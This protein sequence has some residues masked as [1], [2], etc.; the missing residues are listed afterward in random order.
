[1]T[2]IPGLIVG[3]PDGAVRALRATDG[4]LLWRRR[5]AHTAHSNFDM[6]LGQM[7]NLLLAVT[8]DGV[9]HALR[10]R[11][12]VKLWGTRL[13]AYED[14]PQGP[15]FRLARRYVRM[16]AD[17]ERAVVQFL[18]Q[19]LLLESW[20]GR[21]LWRYLSL[22]QETQMVG[23]G[24]GHVFVRE[25][26]A[27]S[28]DPREARRAGRPVPPPRTVTT[29]TLALSLQDGATSWTTRDYAA[30]AAE[31]YGPTS[32]AVSNSLAFCFGERGL[33]ALREATGELVWEQAVDIRFP[34]G[35]LALT[36]GHVAIWANQ[37]LL[38]FR[39]RDG[40]LAW[41]LAA[42]G[43]GLETE[44][45]GALVAM[46]DSIY[47]G[48]RSLKPNSSRIV[49]RDSATGAITWTWPNSAQGESGDNMWRLCGAN[50]TLYLPG[51]SDL[52]ALRAA[53]GQQQ[54]VAHDPQGFFGALLPIDAVDAE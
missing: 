37:D 15:E 6:P 10:L 14:E 24:A 35:K 39:Q 2:E 53:D 5:I 36:T 4:T 13:P 48:R 45:Y 9:I 43:D 38:V 46:G 42:R 18:R 51:Q 47:I 52:V 22:A 44:M 29:E 23:V 33:Y 50:G 31:T 41:S 19:I 25:H 49:A 21:L 32:L 28:E 27:T 8:D 12:G 34:L 16:M 20:S 7:G 3:S 17:G 54:W 11:D 30:R 1:M 40:E 26:N